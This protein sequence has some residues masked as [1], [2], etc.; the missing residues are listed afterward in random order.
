MLGHWM[1]RLL[2]G[3]GVTVTVSLS[4]LAP[5][6][7]GASTSATPVTK[8]DTAS[9]KAFIASAARYDISE[10]KRIP[11][12][13]ANEN[14]YVTKVSSGCSRALTGAPTHASTK[15][16]VAL[17]KFGTELGAT[18]EIDALQPIRGVTDRI[19]KLQAH[20]RFSDPVL[21]WEVHSYAAATSAYLALRPPD[22]CADAR[23]LAA[24][25]YTKL[26]PEGDAFLQDV[27]VVLAPASL[28]SSALLPQMRAYAP[29]AVAQ[30]LKRLP[31][32]QR[33]FDKP[34]ALNNHL[35]ALVRSVFGTTGDRSTTVRRLKGR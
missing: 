1:K 29:A 18:L 2:F 19:G 6:A 5:G 7:A 10:T 13:V 34:L 4:C 26:T 15:Q 28:P 14:A 16:A 17:L 24:S 22:V 3:G 25:H 8:Q 9:T 21:Q 12:I 31:A 30:A 33:R 11:A 35:R 23:A 27:S 32:L 20:L